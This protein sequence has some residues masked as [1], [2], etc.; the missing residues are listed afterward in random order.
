MSKRFDAQPA[1]GESQANSF[2]RSVLYNE[3]IQVELLSKVPAGLYVRYI[4]PM[5]HSVQ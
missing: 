3:L 5:A 4:I 1:S 2:R